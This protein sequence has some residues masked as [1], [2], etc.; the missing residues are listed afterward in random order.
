[1]ALTSAQI[2]SLRSMVERE[3]LSFG[4]AARK[5]GVSRNTAIGAGQRANP[6]IRSTHTMRGGTRLPDTSPEAVERARKRDEKLARNRAAAEA[7]AA[8]QASKAAEINLT[9][10]KAPPPRTLPDGAHVT[11]ENCGP[12]DCR[13]PI[14]DPATPQFHLCGHAQELGSPY[15]TAHR[16]AAAPNAQSHRADLGE[17]DGRRFNGRRATAMRGFYTTASAIAAAARL[18]DEPA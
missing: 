7:R 15:C 9:A 3:G 17:F 10:V 2:V 5:L 14:G 12:D 4:E 6:P 18:E 13:W 8:Y 11:L 16:I 1:M